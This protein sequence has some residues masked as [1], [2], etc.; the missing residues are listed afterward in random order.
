MSFISLFEII[1]VFVPEPCI[2]FWAPESIAE[3]AAVIYNIAK[4]FFAKRIGTFINAPAYL[5]NSDPKNSPD[6]ISLEI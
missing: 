2:F 1:E 6:W 5:L 3:A 4:T